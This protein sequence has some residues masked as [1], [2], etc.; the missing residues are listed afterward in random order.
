MAEVFSRHRV[1]GA[2]WGL[3][4]FPTIRREPSSFKPGSANLLI[5]VPT[6]FRDKFAMKYFAHSD[7]MSEW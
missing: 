6:W 2:A 3:L 7:R 5:G 1:N 4:E